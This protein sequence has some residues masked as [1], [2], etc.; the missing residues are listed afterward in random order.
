MYN[1]DGGGAISLSPEDSIVNLSALE[2]V[3]GR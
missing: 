2:V 1:L 3:E